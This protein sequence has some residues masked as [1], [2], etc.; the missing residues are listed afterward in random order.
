MLP[1]S[2]GKE[3][4]A[5]YAIVNVLK[6]MRP[7]A[8]IFADEKGAE[9]F[10]AF[11]NAYEDDSG[12]GNGYSAYWPNYGKREVLTRTFR[13]FGSAKELDPEM[14]EDMLRSVY[15]ARAATFLGDMKTLFSIERVRRAIAFSMRELPPRVRPTTGD[16]YRIPRSLSADG[17]GGE[18]KVVE[19]SGVTL[20]VVPSHYWQR[21]GFRYDVEVLEIEASQAMRTHDY[22]R[23][24]YPT[25]TSWEFDPAAALSK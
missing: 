24:H 3:E 15:R 1:A 5:M 13:P 18:G 10:L 4:Q 19:D 6:N 9:S 7:V 25:R 2:E 8:L 12:A 22:L 16:M 23:D 14:V 11:V 20:K 21:E 17:M